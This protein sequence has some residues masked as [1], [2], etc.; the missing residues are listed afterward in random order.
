MGNFKVGVK[1]FASV[2]VTSLI[3]VVIGILGYRSLQD[4]GKALSEVAGSA[5]PR[6]A[7]LGLVK[8]GLLAAQSAERTILVP[9]LAN[10]K[11]FDRQRENLKTGLGL[12][13][14]G[15]AMVEG[16]WRD[17]ED[18]AAWKTFNDALAEW[19]ATNAKVVEFVSQNKRSNALTLSIGTS[20]L[21]LRKASTA[22][23]SLLER[24]RIQ[25]D[26]LAR[27]A[28]EQAARRGL[29]LV[30]AAVLC[31]AVSIALGT[32]IT[33]SIVG[34][35]KKSVAFARSVA[36]G[37]LDAML[38][39]KGRDELGELAD[40][41]RRMLDSL[42]ENIAAALRKGEEAAAQAEKACAATA[43]AEAHRLAAEM[44]RH[45]GM[46][47]AAE[48]LT[49]VVEVVTE[50][51]AELAERTEQATRGAAEQSARLS[52]TVASMGEMSATVLDVAQ[53]ASTASDTA[54]KAREQA[55]SGSEVVRRAVAG[56]S[57]ARDKALVLS[58]DMAE[59]G[60]QAEG[61]GRVLGVISD[62]ADQT[63][64]LALNA[65]IEAA[66][67]GEAGRGFAV[68]ADEVR[69]LAEKTMTATAEVG[70]AIRD[71]Q[72]GT[73]KSV[74][75]VREAVGVIESATSL[76]DQSGQALTA[77]VSLVESASDQVRSI[78]AASE[79]QS[80]ASE[81]IE[82]SIAD[83]SRVSG[84]TAQAMERSATAVAD[85]A[86]QAQVL[87]GLIEELR[88]ESAHAAQTALPGGRA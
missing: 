16:L 4:T 37:D 1:L 48:R 58:Q 50:A 69:K 38:A 46:L 68:V 74:G 72:A 30:V 56:I 3:T 84:E 61:I 86:E 26:V 29:T 44:A 6:V 23:G 14:Q 64:L 11:E 82:A 88:G 53:N 70:K 52:E 62:I 24:S 35:L 21:S 12:V 87:K 15:R 7:G 66:R 20:M 25:A 22:L 39:V 78:A 34:P 9:E 13:D 65:A 60:T 76:A 40:A 10:S 71:V 79:E 36:G 85:L 42:K 41:L 81:A 57:A 45:E 2:V 18:V 8:E 5:L 51:S 33:L 75:G 73:H 43:E 67:A 49:A 63:N 47:H 55:A 32:I 17:E 80:A 31:L 54:A 28:R 19:R 59:L 27:S 83:V 77:I